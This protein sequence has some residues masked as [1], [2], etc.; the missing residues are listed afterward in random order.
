MSARRR[1]LLGAAALLLVREA[2]AAGTLEKGVY[3]VRGEAHIND[4]PAKRGMDVK[5]GDIVA[6]A[7]GAE[8]I[9]V[10][11]RDAFLLRGDSRLEVGRAAADVFRLITGALLSVYQ[12]GVRKT[13]HAQT[14]TIGIRGTGIYVESAA[15][16]TYVCTC[17]GEADLIP[18]ADPGARET[19]RTRHH[20][21]PRYI[22]GK[23]A[24][25][26]M[27]KAPVVNHT[28]AE[29]AMIESLVGRGV[30]FD[31]SEYR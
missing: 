29:L 4:A 8:I 30:P 16:R 18:L 27:M 25:Q 12:P 24:P 14:A 23:G 5:R 26:M 20:E 31:P 22:L 3:R 28:D 15:D 2:L 7:T 6:T 9:F 17:Y 13:L 21:Q 11:N 19:V 1:F 10:V